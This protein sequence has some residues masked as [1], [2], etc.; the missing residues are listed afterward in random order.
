LGASHA[1]AFVALGP[2]MAALMAIPALGEW[3][4][5]VAWVAIMIITTGVYLASGGPLG[6]S[7][8]SWRPI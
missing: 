2:I 5:N 8:R 6:A 3:P 4:S 7:P 1:A